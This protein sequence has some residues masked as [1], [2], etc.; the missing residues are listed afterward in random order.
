[1]IQKGADANEINRAGETALLFAAKKGILQFRR[2]VLFE[3]ANFHIFLV[4]NWFLM[5][6]WAINC[7]EVL[8]QNEVSQFFNFTCIVLYSFISKLILIYLLVKSGLE[9]SVDLLIQYGADINTEANDGSSI[10]M[11]AAASGNFKINQIQFIL[12]FT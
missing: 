7:F 8:N 5:F 4:R 9:K 6:L 2:K 1:M 12:H 3:T 11:L 10:L